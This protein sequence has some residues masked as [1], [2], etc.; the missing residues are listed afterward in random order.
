[1]NATKMGLG[2]ILGFAMLLGG[3]SAAR[4]DH[5]GHGYSKV[6]KLTGTP[7]NRNQ[8]FGS[9]LQRKVQANKDSLRIIKSDFG[10]GALP[11]RERFQGGLNKLVV[12]FVQKGKVRQ[13]TL[14]TRVSIDNRNRTEFVFMPRKQFNKELKE[15][16]AE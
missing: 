6:Y 8:Q 3:I 5:P 2:A 10:N 4:A 12:K 16:Q 15:F 14:Y 7:E 13:K 9:I 11:D 1:M